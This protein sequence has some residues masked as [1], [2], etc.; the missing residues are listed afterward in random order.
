MAKKREYK[1]PSIYVVKTGKNFIKNG[2]VYGAGSK[3]KLTDREI[4]DNVLPFKGE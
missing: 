4:D 3:L 1:K 2:I